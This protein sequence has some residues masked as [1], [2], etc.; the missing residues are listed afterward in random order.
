M[1][2]ILADHPQA[3]WHQFDA[4]G[5]ARRRRAPLTHAPIYHFD[6]ADVVVSL[7]ADFLN[8]GPGSVRY[9][10]R[11]R[12]PPR[13]V[14]GR[15]QGDEPAL[16][17]REHADADGR[18]GGSPAAREG[19]GDRSDRPRT[20]PRSAA[21]RS[22][23]RRQRSAP[24]SPDV[25]KWV[26]AIAKDLQAHRGRSLVIAGDYQPAAVH[27]VARAHE[28]GARQRRHDRDLCAGGRGQPDGP[29]CVAC[30]NS[31][32]AMDAGQVA[33]LVILGG[34]PVFTAPGGPQVRREAG[35]GRPGRVSRA[36]RRRDRT[37]GHWNL[38]PAHALESWG[39]ARAYD[40]TVTLMQPLIAPLYEG[41]SAHEM[42][43]VFID[44]GRS[45][46][47]RDRQG[48]L[49]PRLLGRRPVG[50]HRIPTARRSRTPML[51]AARAARRVDRRDGGHRGRSRDPFGARTLAGTAPAI[52]PPQPPAHRA[53]LLD[54]APAPAPARPG[55]ARNHLPSRSRPSGT[56]ASRTTAGCR[57][58]RSR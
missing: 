43:A 11:L 3:R 58:C 55:R 18:E 45:P 41:R 21:D 53:A 25:A 40:G 44:A 50:D 24:G 4:T 35:Q 37:P 26:G 56:A 54:A 9:S 1:S 47:R 20:V 29:P 27:Q 46:R 42:L 52:R 14:D 15:P 22:G 28:P 31:P 17:D 33:L 16:R 7:D 13:R 19:G 5:D 23:S 2:S 34:N 49:D 51:L 10:A 57:N 36:L 12:R 8:C 30:A 39:D 6:K 32:Q 38:P 48:L